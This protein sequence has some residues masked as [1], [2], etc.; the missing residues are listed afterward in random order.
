MT[1]QRVIKVDL[2]WLKQ[3]SQHLKNLPDEDKISRFGVKLTDYSIDQLVLSMLYHSDDHELWV[4][5]Q[6]PETVVGWGHMAKD[7][8]SWELAVS[9]EHEHQR[10]GVGDALISEMLEWAKYH[11]IDEVY[12]H[13]IEDNKVIQHL[14]A[15][16]KLKTRERG[17][18]ERVAAIELPNPSLSEVNSQWFK[19]YSHLVD[20]MTDLRL[21]FFKLMLG[22][23][24]HI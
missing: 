9:V 23:T 19:E 3:Y 4:C 7:G 20:E 6:F 11:H 12:M 22:Q 21:Q 13:C 18:G 14:A 10:K 16:H 1:R 15:K 5:L 24:H 2:Y 8:K 17:Q